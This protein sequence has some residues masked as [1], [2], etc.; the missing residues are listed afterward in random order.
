MFL[1]LSVDQIFVE[2]VQ[3]FVNDVGVDGLRS[4]DRFRPTIRSGRA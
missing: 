2:V 3:V 1:G 4:V